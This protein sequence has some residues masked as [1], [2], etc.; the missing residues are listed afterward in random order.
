[1][2]PASCSAKPPA[3]VI[4]PTEEIRSGPRVEDQGLLSGD[5]G[6]AR[7]QLLDA[8]GL[9]RIPDP[10]DVPSL[11][12]PERPRVGLETQLAAQQGVVPDLRVSVERQVV[13]RKRHLGGEQGAKSRRHRLRQRR[14]LRTPQQP[15]VGE[16]ELGA[17]AHGGLQELQVRRDA[18]GDAVDLGGA[19][20]LEPVR[21][22]VVE[23]ADLEQLVAEADD[24]V[25]GRH[26]PQTTICG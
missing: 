9:F 1:M 11:R 22:V 2:G 23:R 25:A 19:G 20:H 14:H 16:D 21:A 15:V 6:Q 3:P 13:G 18:G 7:R 26:R 5:L 17:G 12:L 4:S 10:P 8:Q 24:L